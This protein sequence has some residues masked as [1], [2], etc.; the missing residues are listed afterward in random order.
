MTVPVAG[1]PYVLTFLPT[2]NG[3]PSDV[4]SV[5]RLELYP[6]ADRTGTA[7]V[8]VQGPATREAVGRYVFA[9]ATMPGAGLYYLR[10]AYTV[11]GVQRFDADDSLPVYALAG[12]VEDVLPSGVTSVDLALLRKLLQDTGDPPRDTDSELAAAMVAGPRIPQEWSSTEGL[13]LPLNPGPD[14]YGLAADLWDMRALELDGSGVEEVRVT[15]ERNVDL[16]LT[17]AGP[18]KAVGAGVLTGERCRAIARQLRRHSPNHRRARTVIVQTE[19]GRRET[20]VRGGLYPTQL[21]N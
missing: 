9:A 8:V 12:T 20:P 2:V 16:T 1:Q 7:T 5:D 3:Q 15:S 10:V 19:N 13:W 6:T 17:Y 14:L 4:G 21:V 18:G 11:A